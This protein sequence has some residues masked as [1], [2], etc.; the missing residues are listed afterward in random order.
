MHKQLQPGTSNVKKISENVAHH[1]FSR[2]QN[3]SKATML[4]SAGTVAL[5]AARA[6]AQEAPI[7]AYLRIK[8]AIT[9]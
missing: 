5:S 6:A 7:S 1:Y 8:C 3:R 9:Y 4:W 2:R